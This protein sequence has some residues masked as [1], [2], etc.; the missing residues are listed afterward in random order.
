MGIEGQMRFIDVGDTGDGLAPAGS[1]GAP[2]QWLRELAQSIA[3]RR[4]ARA[5]SRRALRL[6]AQ[7]RRERPDLAGRA[8]YCEIIARCLG[9]EPDRA[10]AYVRHAE[11]SFAAWPVSRAVRF[12]DVVAYVIIEERVIAARRASARAD[13][14]AVVASLIPTAL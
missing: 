9:G 10:R 4:Y 1:L 11:D 2:R 3:D 6:H 5:E 14:A 7:V 8:L 12:R 13:I